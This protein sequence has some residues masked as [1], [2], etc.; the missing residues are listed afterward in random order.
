VRPADRSVTIAAREL[1]VLLEGVR[2]R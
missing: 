2:T 1:A